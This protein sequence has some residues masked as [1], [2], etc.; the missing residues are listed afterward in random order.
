MGARAGSRREA[1][2]REAKSRAPAR[3]EGHNVAMTEDPD[4]LAHAGLTLPRRRSNEGLDDAQA[5]LASAAE[6]IRWLQAA[7]ALHPATRLLDFGCGQGRLVNG[8]AW[9]GTPV[10]DY[11]GIDTNR[12]AIDWCQ[13]HLSGYRAPYRFLHLP[14]HNARYNPGAEERPALPLEN[15]AVDL[16]FLNSVFSHMLADDVRFYLG[17]FRRVLAPRGRLYLTAFI[18]DG[19]P[20]VEENPAGY[21]G[22]HHGALHRVRYER[23]FFLGML[24]AGGF[25]CLRFE[26]EGITRTGQ[27]VVLAA[28]GG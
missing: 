23:G 22:E 6:Q 27:S 17:E 10:A 12:T 18:E 13:R 24:E 21:R 1:E 5:Y 11:L 4:H 7:D 28:V 9:T 15:G 14:A 20:A 8:L 19:V 25:E 2:R 3:H 16:V 26:H